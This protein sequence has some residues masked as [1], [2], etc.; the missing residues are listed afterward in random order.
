MRKQGKLVHTPPAVACVAKAPSCSGDPATE[1]GPI[2]GRQI[3]VLD[4]AAYL[5]VIYTAIAAERA[6]T[7]YVDGIVKWALEKQADAVESA[8]ETAP[9][10]EVEIEAEVVETVPAAARPAP[11][12]IDA[13]IDA[14]IDT[15]LDGFKPVSSLSK[16]DVR[17]IVNEIARETAQTITIKI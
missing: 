1:G 16:D 12:S 5:S 17:Q 2:T 4:S 15:R 13:M 8:P 6:T 9:A 11:G 3:A 14:R 10:E 7:D